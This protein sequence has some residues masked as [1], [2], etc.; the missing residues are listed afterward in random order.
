MNS[1]NTW[2]RPRKLRGAGDIIA[3]AAK[4]IARAIDRVAGTKLENCGACAKRQALMNTA[5]PFPTLDNPA[6]NG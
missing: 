2:K 1:E 5:I 6:S 4:P 3:L